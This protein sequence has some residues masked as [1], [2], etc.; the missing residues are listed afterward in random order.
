MTDRTTPPGVVIHPAKLPMRLPSEQLHI[1]PGPDGV[2]RHRPGALGLALPVVPGVRARRRRD[3]ACSTDRSRKRRS[4]R[5]PAAASRSTVDGGSPAP[6]PRP[7]VRLRGDALERL[8]P[9]GATTTDHRPATARDARRRRR[10]PG[11]ADRPVRRRRAS[12]SSSS[13]ATSRSRSAA[14]GN[15]TRQVNNIMMPDFPADRLLICEVFTPSGN[16]SG[17]PPAQARR[18]RSAARG[19]PRG[20]VLLPAAAG[21]R[22]GRSSGSTTAT[23]RGTG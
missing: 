13:R 4:S 17:W 9:A 22:A 11:A 3:D 14:R 16:W 5:S 8:L 15:A 10:R 12:R 7:A 2:G 1:R 18:R 21:P 19:G 6:A 23:A 20:D